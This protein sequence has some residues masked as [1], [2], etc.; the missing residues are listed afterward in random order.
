MPLRSGSITWRPVWARLANGVGCGPL[1]VLGSYYVQAQRLTWE[2]FW[3]SAPVGLLIA[4]VLY[5]NEFPDEDLDAASGRK[6]VPVVLGRDRAVWGYVALLSA[7]YVIVVLGVIIG[8]FPG[9]L[10]LALLTL[11]LA[12]RAA[13]T[14]VVYHSEVAS[15]IPAMATTV[16]I[17]S[18]T[19]ILPCL[20]YVMARVL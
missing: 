18:G 8:L 9:W 15:L 6:T 10:C 3:V 20:G 16:L 12:S 14:A 13:R 11:P 2:A 1:I 5:I 4:A 19:S 7:A 17:H